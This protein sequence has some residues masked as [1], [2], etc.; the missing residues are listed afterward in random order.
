MLQREPV[1]RQNGSDDCG[2]FAV[3]FIVELLS[4]GDP[5]TVGFKQNMM[6]KHYSTC[7]ETSKWSPFPKSRAAVVRVPAKLTSFKVCW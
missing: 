6:R 4:G 5:S 3:A 1:Q 7:L 2:L